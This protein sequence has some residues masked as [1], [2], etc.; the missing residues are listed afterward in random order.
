MVKE[1][2]VENIPESKRTTSRDILLIESESGNSAFLWGDLESHIDKGWSVIS[3]LQINHVEGEG[4]SV[5][6]ESK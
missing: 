3:R 5:E 1:Q 6:G 4:W 2:Q